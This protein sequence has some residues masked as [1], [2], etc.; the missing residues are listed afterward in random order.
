MSQRLLHVGS[1]PVLLGDGDEHHAHHQNH[2]PNRHQGRSQD[3]GHLPKVAGEVEAT[4]D[5][6]TRQEAAA[7]GHEVDGEPEDFALAVRGLGGPEGLAAGQAEHSALRPARGC[8]LVPGL[9]EGALSKRDVL[10]AARHGHLEDS[11]Y[12]TGEGG[13]SGRH[14]GLK[15]NYFNNNTN[16]RCQKVK[17][18]KIRSI[19]FYLTTYFL[20]NKVNSSPPE[21]P[22]V[23]ENS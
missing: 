20:P 21:A 2:Q 23:P 4:D 15:V 11:V 7:G 6:A 5:E 10:W 13:R 17:E 22:S 1:L 9:G 19:I 8:Q 3:G 18:V 12:V 14:A 16:K